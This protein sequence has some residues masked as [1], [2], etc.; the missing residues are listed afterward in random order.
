MR[1]VKETKK[2]LVH[3][4][5]IV[6]AV[7]MITPFFWMLTTSLK[8]YAESMKVPPKLLPSVWHFENYKAVIDKMDFIRYYLNTIFVTVS[9]TAGQLV[10]CSLAAYSFARLRFPGKKPAVH[11]NSERIDGTFTGSVDSEFRYYEAVE[12]VGHLLRANRSGHLQR[13]RHVSDETVFL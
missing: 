12:L 8:S 5:L 7:V 9:R 11:R 13:F 1:F 3:L 2:I 4:I 6:G 10:L